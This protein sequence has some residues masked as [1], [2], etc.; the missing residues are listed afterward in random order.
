MTDTHPLVE[1]VARCTQC[2]E[3]SQGAYD[4]W[5]LCVKHSR[6]RQMRTA[7]QSNGKLV[8]TQK[9]LVDLTPKD[10]T[11][12]DCGVEMTWLKRDS[13]RKV[14]TLQHYRDGTLAI[15]CMSCN[16][17]HGHSVG[18]IYREI[19]PNFKLC[20]ACKNILPV[21]DFTRKRDKNGPW[22]YK[23]LCKKC[24]REQMR[25]DHATHRDYRNARQRFRYAE[26]KAA[27][28]LR[29]IEGE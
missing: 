8:P 12:P 24:N 9:Q 15:V 16:A 17:K 26:R 13:P 1:A 7:A 29:E 14:A 25:K 21:L 11:C 6:Y 28:I 20:R 2:G 23:N 10:M 19:G 4:N 3:P 27:A 18:D 22:Y 5:S